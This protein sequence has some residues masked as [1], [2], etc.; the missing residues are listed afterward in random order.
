ML[1]EKVEALREE[2][3]EIITMPTDMPVATQ[4]DV[5]TSPGDDWG[6]NDTVTDMVYGV[7]KDED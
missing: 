4:L 7:R 3:D 2:A 6:E 5:F 1:K